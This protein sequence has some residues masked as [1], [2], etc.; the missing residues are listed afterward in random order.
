MVR[1]KSEGQLGL[2]WGE[3]PQELVQ[4]HAKKPAL[5]VTPSGPIKPHEI[6]S[7]IARDMEA[8][9]EEHSPW[10]QKFFEDRIGMYRQWYAQVAA[11][12]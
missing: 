5:I 12:A 2:D 10:W 6:V 9:R 8:L 7:M 4:L 11:S 1:R 3:S